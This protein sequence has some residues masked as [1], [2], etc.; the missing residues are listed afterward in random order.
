MCTSCMNAEV[1]V[2]YGLG[3]HVGTITLPGKFT[4]WLLKGR[5]KLSITQGTHSLKS[6]PQE[7]KMCRWAVQVWCLALKVAMTRGSKFL[8]GS[9]VSYNVPLFHFSSLGLFSSLFFPASATQLHSIFL[10]FLLY[11]LSSSPSLPSAG[12]V[13]WH[14]VAVSDFTLLTVIPF[15]PGESSF[16]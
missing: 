8:L 9:W 5:W 16:G 3:G 2:L 6:K 13:E 11:S 7:I 10:S 15:F 14:T 12:G 1:T 4:R